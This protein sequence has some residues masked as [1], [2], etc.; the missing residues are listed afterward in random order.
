ML[1]K[2]LFVVAVAA[3]VALLSS[4]TY[5]RD[6]VTPTTQ[7]QTGNNSA[8]VDWEFD[9]STSERKAEAWN[10]PATSGGMTAGRWKARASASSAFSRACASG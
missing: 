1:K 10:W 5:A 6:Y 3:V 7:T 4:G 9:G 2:S 8:N